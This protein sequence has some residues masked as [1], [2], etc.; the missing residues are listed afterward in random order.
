MYK[1]NDIRNT[2][3]TKR[4]T[5]KNIIKLLVAI[6]AII[7]LSSCEKMGGGK[8]EISNMSGV[9]FYDCQVWFRDTEDGEL[10]GYEKAGN[11]MMGESVKVKKLGKFCYIYAKDVRGNMVMTKTKTAYD[12]M[13]FSKYDL[14]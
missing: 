6:I 2:N 10:N 5:V 7:S 12:G 1:R 11:V 13:S 14:L 3:Q 4:T 9:S 8:I